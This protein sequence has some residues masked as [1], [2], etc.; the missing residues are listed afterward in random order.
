[1]QIICRRFFGSHKETVVKMLNPYSNIPQNIIALLD[2]HLIGID[3]HPLSII[4]EQIKISLGPKF[5][6]SGKLDRVLKT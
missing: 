3:N 2:R 5:N 6:V 4:K 1:M